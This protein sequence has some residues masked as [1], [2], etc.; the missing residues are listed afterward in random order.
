MKRKKV[1]LE[2]VDRYIKL[3]PLLLGKAEEHT[4]G[5]VDQ[6]VEAIVVSEVRDPEVADEYRRSIEIFRTQPGKSVVRFTPASARITA[7]ETGVKPFSIKD[8][9]LSSPKAKLSKDGYLYRTVP[10]EHDPAKTPGTDKGKT[11]LDKINEIV[12]GSRFALQFAKN[13]EDSGKF[14]VQDRLKNENLVRK[15]VFSSEE[16]YRSRKKPLS[17]Q[18]TI[19]RTMSSKP[20]TS[21][22]FHPGT[23][24]K[25][26][27]GQVDRWL[28]E[29]EARVFEETFDELFNTYFGS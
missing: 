18:Y 21:E 27:A 6:V 24:G 25:N 11:A 29:N 15:R 8:K 9:M 16:D 2:D 4:Q 3:L 1:K 28:V 14:V 10:I 5:V 12:R 19:F 7:I 20:G 23:S 22:W 17:R 13:L 26:I